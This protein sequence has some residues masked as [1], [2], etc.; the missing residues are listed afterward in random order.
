MTY[1]V[2]ERTVV[3]RKRAR[4][5]VLTGDSAA[6]RVLLSTT[7]LPGAR[8]TVAYDFAPVVVALLLEDV[9]PG[10]GVQME[11]FIAAGALPLESWLLFR[12][13][14]QLVEIH[15]WL[16]FH[17]LRPRCCF[18]YCLRRRTR[19]LRCRSKDP[20]CCRSFAEW[21]SI[22]AGC[23]ACLYGCWKRWRNCRCATSGIPGSAF[24]RPW[25][26]VS[27]AAS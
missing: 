6:A 4:P 5:N 12:L 20:D 26:C 10:I 14:E 9:I 16:R 2:V 8:I 23:G 24:A 18:C 19:W 1:L 25:T 27:P 13:D 15:L 11:E 7:A 3:A 17:Y 22:R 21:F